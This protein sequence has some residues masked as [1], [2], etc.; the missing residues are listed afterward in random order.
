MSWLDD[1]DVQTKEQRIENEHKQK[2]VE[3]R[4]RRDALIKETDHMML[5][6]YPSPSLGLAEYRKSLRDITLQAGF[7][8]YVI[9]PEL[10]M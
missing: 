4:R 9:W 7:P 6:D 2:C 3:I 1:A 8:N 10:L 5:P